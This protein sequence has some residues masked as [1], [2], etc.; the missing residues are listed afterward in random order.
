[1]Q[2]ILHGTTQALCALFGRWPLPQNC[3]CI[4]F[5]PLLEDYEEDPDSSTDSCAINMIAYNSKKNLQ[6]QLQKLCL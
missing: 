6:E 5:W 2:G 3:V 1:M 4:T